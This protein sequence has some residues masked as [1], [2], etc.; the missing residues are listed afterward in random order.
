MIIY[1]SWLKKKLGLER[2]VF[3]KTPRKIARRITILAQ[4][5]K[6]RGF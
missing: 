2:Q 3:V 4:Q 5:L 1:Y 6:N